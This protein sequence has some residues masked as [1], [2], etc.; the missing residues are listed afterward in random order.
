VTGTITK[1]RQKN[2]KYSWGYVFDAGAAG[3]TRNQK[4]KQGFSTKKAAEDALRAAIVNHQSAPQS[5]DPRTF[6]DFF[7][8]WITEHA[9]RHCE[10]K[11]V[12]RY[13]E[14]GE[15][16]KRQFGDVPIIDL[17]PLIL[18]KALNALRDH[19]G[20]KTPAHPEGRPLA[21]KTVREIAS[22]VNGTIS[23]AIRWQILQEN[24]MRYVKLPKAERKQAKALE[25]SH[26]E[27]V[28]TWAED[29][30]WLHPLIE[31]DAATGCRRGELLALSWP[32][33]DFDGRMLTV[34]K[35]LQQSKRA[36][37]RIKA[38]KSGKP[39]RFRLPPSALGVLRRH[40]ELQ[41]INRNTFGEDYKT[42][43]DL[44]FGTPDGDYLKPD[45]VSAKVSL[46]MRRLGLPKGCSLHTLR[47]THASHL[48]SEH[49][50]LP[51]VSKRLG[52]A[53]PNVTAIIYA[54]ALD[55]D[56]DEAAEAWERSIGKRKTAPEQSKHQ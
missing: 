25:R 36:G 31:L 48:L 38:P 17:K 30:P 29:H 10:P 51:A 1:Y 9:E 6:S 13:E 3:K 4:T 12:D 33:I 15:Y 2:G 46:L 8:V 7:K 37:L 40:R 56:D 5:R 19:G 45:S 26:L 14:L 50:P 49:V 54:H 11:T 41:Q 52:H 27:T 39:R 34:S 23:T 55:R 32:D 43:L 35:S 18:E 22:V 24:P 42:E 44:V 47:H 21:P 53:N 16:A 20:K 28:S